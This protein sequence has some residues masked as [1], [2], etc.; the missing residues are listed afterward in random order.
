MFGSNIFL[1]FNIFYQL[2]NHNYSVHRPINRIG[3]IQT[4]T[5]QAS[6]SETWNFHSIRVAHHQ[7]PQS[8]PLH[9]SFMATAI[10]DDRCWSAAFSADSATAV[11]TTVENLSA[12]VMA[13]VLRRLDDASLTVVGACT[14]L[15]NLVTDPNAWRT[16][17]LALSPL[18]RDVATARAQE[19]PT[20]G[21]RAAVVATTP[22]RSIPRAVRPQDRRTRAERPRLDAVTAK[23]PGHG[24]PTVGVLPSVP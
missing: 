16:L 9:A 2:F 1:T 3:R 6:S 12:D 17:C 19:A 18:L 8:Y 4:T 20:A 22:T 11:V 23:V 15:G 5:Q 21:H 14:A 10:A 13:Q 24:H 7:P